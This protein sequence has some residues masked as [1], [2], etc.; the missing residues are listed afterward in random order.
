MG[1]SME[2]GPKN[3]ISL[4][5]HF[6]MV[7]L[8]IWDHFIIVIWQKYLYK[9]V[10]EIDICGQKS[11]LWPTLRFLN[12]IENRNFQKNWISQKWHFCPQKSISE[13]TIYRYF[14]HITI[15]K[16]SQICKKSIRKS[17]FRDI[18]FVG[19]FSIEIPI[20]PFKK[21]PHDKKWSNP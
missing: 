3:K 13:T 4:K 11:I 2:N 21:W 18:L 20:V 6:L 17:F 16:W 8:Q 1:I 10:L 5:K 15:L 14:C 12:C 19:R 9:V 7:F